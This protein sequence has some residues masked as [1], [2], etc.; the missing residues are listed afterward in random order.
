MTDEQFAEELKSR[1]SNP[2][3][4]DTEID[5][6]VVMAKRDVSSANYSADDYISQVLDTACYLL[7]L[8]NK[9]PE[10]ASTSQNG[11]TT[12]FSGN[13]SERWRRRITERRQAIIIA[14]EL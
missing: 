10:I 4:S 1:L 11:L 7:S 6:Y 2:A 14:L 3:I 8:D 12:S 5:K 9:F 13:D